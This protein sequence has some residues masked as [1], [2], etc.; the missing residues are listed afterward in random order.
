MAAFLRRIPLPALVTAAEDATGSKDGDRPSSGNGCLNS[1]DELIQ[2]D[3]L[4]A[5]ATDLDETSDNSFCYHAIAIGDTVVGNLSSLIARSDAEGSND[6]DGADARSS[7]WQTS[8][9]APVLTVTSNTSGTIIASATATHVSLLKGHD[10]SI[11]ATR[12]ITRSGDDLTATSPGLVFVSSSS[13]SNNNPQQSAMKDVLVVVCPVQGGE[14]DKNN[15]IVISNIDGEALNSSDAQRFR[16]GATN[17]SIDALC[18]DTNAERDFIAATLIEGV[19]IND[20]AIRFFVAHKSGIISVYDYNIASKQCTF[21]TDDLFNQIGMGTWKYEEQ[22]GMSIDTNNSR[23]GLFLVLAASNKSAE[24]TSIGWIN[25]L[26]LSIAANYPISTAGEK[27]LSLKPLRSN[28]PDECVVVAFSTKGTST[29][30][31]RAES[32]KLFILQSLLGKVG[33]GCSQIL[34]TVQ[35]DPNVRAVEICSPPAM[36]ASEA[37]SFRFASKFDGATPN[38][39]K[40]FIPSEQGKVGTVH[41]LLSAKNDFDDAQ[42]IITEELATCSSDDDV[43]STPIHK[44]LVWLWRCRHILST[45]NKDNRASSCDE[46]QQSLRQLTFGAATGDDQFTENMIAAAEFMLHWPEKGSNSGNIE[47]SSVSLHDIQSTLSILCS[48]MKKVIDVLRSSPKH[49]YLEEL[50]RKINSRLRAIQGLEYVTTLDGSQVHLND[51]Y[52]AVD[53]IDGLLS[54]LVSQAAFRSAERLQKSEYGTS[55]TPDSISSAALRIPLRSDSTKFL[56]WLCDSVIPSLHIGH[57]K[58]D[59][60]RAWACKAA[61]FYDEEGI[62][63]GIESSISLLKAVSNATTKLSVAMNSMSALPAQVVVAGDKNMHV[64]DESISASIH[65]RPSVLKVGIIRGRKIK[66]GRTF[67]AQRGGAQPPSCLDDLENIEYDCVE[68]KL[69]E[70]TRLKRARELG[71]SK[72]CL[73]LSSYESK[74]DHYVVKELV[75][76]DLIRTS[77]DPST[78]AMVVDGVKQ[79]S[80]DVHVDFDHAMLQFSIELGNSRKDDIPHYLHDAKRLAQWCDSPSVMC[81]IVLSM[82]QKALVSIQRPPDLSQIAHS[83]IEAATDDCTKSELKEAARLL[84]IDYLVRKYCG[85]GAQ[86]YFR[87]VR[88]NITIPVSCF[89]YSQI[90]STLT[91]FRVFSLILRMAFDSS[92][93]CVGMSTLTLC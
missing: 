42:H 10:G 9:D 63:N 91:S 57:P 48:E 83:A 6:G 56:P 59:Y 79:F 70:A 44:S 4:A 16:E 32:P 86:E 41:Y 24:A 21:V 87:V 5:L 62:F 52:L 77:L 60:I 33:S 54:I 73:T 26:D 64:T 55:L 36:Y 1:S 37:Y 61:D 14:W 84:S 85:N 72:D 67:S 51:A 2:N 38:V 28:H 17:M 43:I 3:G 78:S 93:M 69:N 27:L 23:G 80:K 90:P 82:L 18:F 7:E 58:L 71:M 31:K 88:A 22:L 50:N 75:K 46:F 13:S 47:P 34:F 53:S 19:F 11:I 20:D 39:Y 66:Q 30:M 15:V 89:A 12:Q 8:F 74:G 35:T 65:H 92:N 76:S 25:V 29:R 45:W 40:E 68:Q 81:L 49:S